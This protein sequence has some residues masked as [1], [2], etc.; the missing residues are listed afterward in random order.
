MISEAA[1]VADAEADVG[2]V[3]PA[4]VAAT[5]VDVTARDA[6]TRPTWIISFVGGDICNVVSTVP[7][8]SPS[9]DCAGNVTDV[10]V[11][12]RSGVIV[13]VYSNGSAADSRVPPSQ[14]TEKDLL[15]GA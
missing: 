1:A 9:N 6:P 11:D 14:K 10:G 13:G 4:E 15:I 7:G 3:H 12:A 2:A 5:Y 8:S